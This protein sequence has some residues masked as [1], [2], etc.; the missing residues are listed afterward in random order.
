[1]NIE[2]SKKLIKSILQTK[3]VRSIDFVEFNPMMDIND[4]TLKT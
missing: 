1:M 4:I 2:Q 3:L